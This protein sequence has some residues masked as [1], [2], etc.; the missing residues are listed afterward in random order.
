MASF[1]IKHTEQRYFSLC[2]WN[3][4]WVCWCGL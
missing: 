3:S 2:E 4:I 1:R